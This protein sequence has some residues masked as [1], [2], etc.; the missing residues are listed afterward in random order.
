MQGKTQIV[1]MSSMPK[2]L[3]KFKTMLIEILA[4]FSFVFK[5]PDKLNSKIYIENKEP[6]LPKQFGRRTSCDHKLNNNIKTYYQIESFE[7]SVPFLA[8]IISSIL[9][10]PQN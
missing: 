3:Y 6:R 7:I 9:A 10:I 8:V 5:K 2:L 4:D 1:K